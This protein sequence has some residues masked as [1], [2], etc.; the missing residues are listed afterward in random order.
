MTDETDTPMVRALDGECTD[1]LDLEKVSKELYEVLVT[2]TEGEAK[3]MVKNVLNND[4]VWA[5]RLYRHYNRRTLARVLRMTREALHPKAVHDLKQLT[6]KVVEWEDKWARMAAEH[7]ET[8]P[9]IWKIVAL[10]ELCPP[11]VQD[12]VCQDVDG[13]SKKLRQT[14]AEDPGVGREQGRALRGARSH[15]RRLGTQS[16]AGRARR[17]GRCRSCH[18]EYGVSGVWRLRALEVGVSDS[19]AER[20][21]ESEG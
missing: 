12:L 21:G 14:Q 2:I 18:H 20:E 7:K 9:V 1:R 5:Y 17:T 10:M 19:S 8:H 6:S 15:G 13:V 3:L 11:D 16:G 4:G